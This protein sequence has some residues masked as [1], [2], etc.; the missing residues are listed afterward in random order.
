MSLL[1]TD[2]HAP[3]RMA[4]LLV[5]VALLMAAGYALVAA[6]PGAPVSSPEQLSQVVGERLAQVSSRLTLLPSAAPGLAALREAA[7]HS[8]LDDLFKILMLIFDFVVKLMDPTPL[9]DYAWKFDGVSARGNLSLK[10]LQARH[11]RE[12]TVQK[13]DIH[14]STLCAEVSLLLPHLTLETKYDTDL[15]FNL[16][17]GSNSDFRLFGNGQA[18]VDMWNIKMYTD[19]CMTV[20]PV[21]VRVANMKLSVEKDNVDVQNLFCDQA[22]S[23]SIS[24]IATDVVPSMVQEFQQEITNFIM[25]YI[26]KLIEEKL[27]H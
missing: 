15:N 17:D 3:Q 7:L 5:F 18:K 13:Y 25:K 19:L 22:V 2:Q 24:Q 4:R 16:E 1:S 14:L 21:T 12:L 9:G 8:A 11:L 23:K 20:N 6:A 26:N 10:G 27:P